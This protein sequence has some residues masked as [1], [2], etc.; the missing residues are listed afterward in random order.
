MGVW[1]R[2]QTQYPRTSGW[3]PK[4]LTRSKDTP[5]LD[6]PSQ[7]LKLTLDTGNQGWLVYQRQGFWLEE[8]RV[9]HLGCWKHLN[10]WPD[11][12]LQELLTSW[13]LTGLYTYDLHDILYWFYISINAFLRHLFLRKGK[14]Y[15]ILLCDR[16]LLFFLWYFQDFCQEYWHISLISLSFS[17]PLSLSNCNTKLLD[18]NKCNKLNKLSEYVL[19]IQDCVILD[20]GFHFFPKVLITWS[21]NIH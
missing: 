10:S 14:L 7:E 21:H 17:P 19:K 11:W 8:D 15:N 2:A 18:K 12:C 20:W 1:K 16:C 9:G 13:Q 5:K 3:E 6:W 4:G